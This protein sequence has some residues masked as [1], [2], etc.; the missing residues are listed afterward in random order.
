M[1][2]KNVSVKASLS[3]DKLA[4]TKNF[5]TTI[6]RTKDLPEQ[7]KSE[8]GRAAEGVFGIQEL[9]VGGE[10]FSAVFGRTNT[11]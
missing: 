9:E 3:S 4:T 2:T 11:L 8:E 7:L 5:K 1:A 10:Q 6:V